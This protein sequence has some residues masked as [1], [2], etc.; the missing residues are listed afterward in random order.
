MHPD[1]SAAFS[2]MSRMRAGLGP[3]MFVAPALPVDKT[4]QLY[5]LWC[6]IGLLAAV[7]ERFP[8]SRSK[9]ADIL[10]GCEAPDLLGVKLARGGETEIQL[11]DQCYLTYQRRIGPQTS[12]DGAKTLVVD[13]I[14]DL[15]LSHRS[16]D[17]ACDGLVILDPKYRTGQ[18]LIDGVRDMHVYR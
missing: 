10:R 4:Y 3:G 5:E 13:V 7:A 11:D 14:P 17:G 12:F 2:A 8:Q 15:C 1:Y 6:Y 9:I 16:Q 18:S